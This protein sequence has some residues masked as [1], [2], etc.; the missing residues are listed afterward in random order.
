LSTT[1]R[2]N[3]QLYHGVI[4]KLWLNDNPSNISVKS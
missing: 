1:E 2:V 3:Y 4:D